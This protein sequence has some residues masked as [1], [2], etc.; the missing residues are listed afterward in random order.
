MKMLCT[1][2]NSTKLRP[3]SMKV[4]LIIK[5]SEAP[6]SIKVLATLCRSI[7]ILTTKGR[8]LSDS[9]I[10][11]WSSG[12]NEMP[13]LDHLILLSGSIRWARLISHWSFFPYV[14]EV[15]DMLP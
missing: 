5:F 15:M 12:P 14:L 6:L 2:V 9:S 8:F 3:I 7:G 13:T 11:R 4:F 1:G 10:S